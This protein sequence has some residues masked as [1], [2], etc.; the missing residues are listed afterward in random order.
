MAAIG[1]ILGALS[2]ISTIIS[3]QTTRLD[4]ISD[5]EQ[6]LINMADTKKTNDNNRLTSFNKTQK[7]L[8]NSITALNSSIEDTTEVRDTSLTTGSNAAAGASQ[9]ATLNYATLLGTV[10]NAEGT[11]KAQAASSGFRMSD[12]ALNTYAI[13]KQSGSKSVQSFKLQSDLQNNSNYSTVASNYTNANN[14][15][16]N[17][18]L[19]VD[20]NEETVDTN[21]SDYDAEVAL[22]NTTYEHQTSYIEEQIDYL[23][24]EGK[25]KS[26]GTGLLAYAGAV[27]AGAAS[28]I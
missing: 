25:W 12:S 14:Q 13:A 22:A 16:D 18:Q 19:Q 11:G 9:L 5:Y 4:T 10:K 15:I 28:P 26:I 3:Q 23:E 20:Q 17:Y 1:V 7:G 2:G 27:G 8:A 6:N 24:G 21:Q